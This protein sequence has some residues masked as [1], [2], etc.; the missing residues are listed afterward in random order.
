MA[1]IAPWLIAGLLFSWHGMAHAHSQSSSR[2]TLE[3]RDGIPQALSVEVAL[4]DLLHWI[5]LDQDADAQL[6]WGE[7][8]AARH[9]ILDLVVGNLQI[10]ADDE[11]CGIDAENRAFLFSGHAG[12]PGLRIELLVRCP[13]AGKA[14]DYLLRYSLFFDGNPSHKSLLRIAGDAGESVHLLSADNRELRLSGAAS[15]VSTFRSFVVEGFHHILSGYDHL[16]FLLLLI[17]P[18]AGAGAMRSRLARIAG[19]VTAFTVAHSITLAAAMTGAVRLPA[20]PVEA[21]I[22]ASIVLAAVMNVIRPRHTLGWKIAFAF[23][24]LHGFGFA[25]ALA[26]LGLAPKTLWSGLLAFNIGIELGQL[27]VTAASLPLFMVMSLSAR[28]RTLLVRSASLACAVL[29][30]IWTAARV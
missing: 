1:R 18:A 24:L 21:A 6:T 25:G 20:G 12:T 7:V 16:I 29:G 17:L 15:E 14:A 22:A 11:S 27:A 5:D 19:I 4:I 23:G 3:T 13:S 8:L 26:E 2:M 10:E 28:Y 30:V 9:A